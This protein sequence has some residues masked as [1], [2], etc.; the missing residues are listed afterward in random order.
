MRSRNKTVVIYNTQTKQFKQVGTT[1]LREYTGGID[2]E[3]IAAF[4]EAIKSPEEFLGV[5]GSSKFFIETKD[6]LS[7]C[8]NVSVWFY[9]QE[10]SRRD[11][12]RSAI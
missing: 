10:E 3:A 11:K 9:E 8:Y 1:C 12:R 2:A 5:S 6:Y 4:E 7:C